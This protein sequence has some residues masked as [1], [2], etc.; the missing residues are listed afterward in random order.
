MPMLGAAGHTLAPGG[1]ARAPPGVLGGAPGPVSGTS[2]CSVS[3]HSTWARGPAVGLLRVSSC[4]QDRVL[5]PG[6]SRPSPRTGFPPT[7][8]QNP[9]L[10]LPELPLRAQGHPKMAD[11]CCVVRPSLLTRLDEG[12]GGLSLEASGTA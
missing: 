10:L 3:T 1:F 12:A 2:R 8:I 5:H 9:D 11:G 4:S 6:S 7:V